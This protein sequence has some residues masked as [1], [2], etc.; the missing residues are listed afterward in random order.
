[1]KKD[2][3]QLA[4]GSFRLVENDFELSFLLEDTLQMVAFQA[5]QRGIELKINMDPKIKSRVRN[6]PNRIRQIVTNFLS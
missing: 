5:Q 1:M 4:S 3:L 2:I 6:D